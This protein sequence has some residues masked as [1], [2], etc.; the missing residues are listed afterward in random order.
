MNVEYDSRLTDIPESETVNCIIPRVARLA[1][2][3]SIALVALVSLQDKLSAVGRQAQAGR[4]TA[5]TTFGGGSLCTLS[6]TTDDVPTRCRRPALSVTKQIDPTDPDTGDL[7]TI[8]F[9]ITGLGPKPVDVVL[10]QDV[11]GSMLTEDAADG[12]TRLA[13]AQAAASTFVK[14]LTGTY[15]VAVVALSDTARLTRT[16]TPYTNTVI[17]AL[18]SLT[19]CHEWHTN[20]GG[21]IISGYQ[22]LISSDRY[23]S[24]FVKAMILLSDGSANR[25]GSVISAEQYALSQTKKARDCGILIY[26]IGFG[27]T[28]EL[29]EELLYTIAYTTGG[30]YYYSPDGSD[31]DTIYQEIALELRNLV[32]TD[33]LPPGVIL[34]CDLLPDDWICIKGSGF[35]TI[36]IPVSNSAI[37]TD[38][39]VLS[40]TTTVH[41]DP[42][43]NGPI[44]ASGSEICYDGPVITPCQAFEN[45]TTT[46][47]G[48]KV[49]GSVFEDLDRDGVLDTGEEDILSG[50]QLTASNALT[51]VT[52]ISGVY[53]FRT[54]DRPT[55]T[56]AVR[57][58]PNFIATTSEITQIPPFSGT[59]QWNFGLYTGLI[60]E[61][62]SV[63][64]NGPPLFE[65]DTL[66]YTIVVRN[67][68]TTL[69]PSVVITD[70]IP[71]FT[72]Y[73]SDSAHITPSGTVTVTGKTLTGVIDSLLPEGTVT[74]TFLVTVDIGATGQMIS[75]TAYVTST[76]QR[77]ILSQ[78]DQEGPYRVAPLPALLLDLAVSDRVIRPNTKVI[79]S[80]IV[81]NV[82]TI[83]TL[84]N[85]VVTDSHVGLISPTNFGLSPSES[86][87]LDPAE[88]TLTHNQISTAVVTSGV[89]GYSSIITGEQATITVHVIEGISLTQI[90][91]EPNPM[92]H[93]D[94]ITL[95]YSVVNQDQ[96]DSLVN[97]T[98][99]IRDSLG[100]TF[101][102]EHFFDL[103]PGIPVSLS[104]FLNVS[105]DIVITITATATDDIEQVL[106]VSDQYTLPLCPVDT[107]EQEND[108]ERPV[109]RCNEAS[110]SISVGEQPQLHDFSK[111]G[112]NG[113]DVDW[114]CFSTDD[115][116][117]PYTF[118]AHPRSSA[119]V[120]I[121]LTLFDASSDH[122]RASGSN[123][124]NPTS[125]VR[126]GV[127]F[128]SNP[129]LQPFHILDKYDYHLKVESA[130]GQS[131]CWTDY[132]LWVEEGWPVHIWLPVILRKH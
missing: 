72:S 53:V 131:G 14:A 32:I 47:G 51:S 91:T 43:Y 46:V 29:N 103:Y 129:G 49:T 2:A 84:T 9:I 102:K 68:S 98:I 60:E 17:A 105:H 1:L 126:L 78:L 99:R 71:F 69:Y 11:S 109:P 3:V 125:D 19:A 94:S 74:I 22:E 25:P 113:Q 83:A 35:T 117:T 116:E 56:V 36:T 101:D 97:G 61:K 30:E 89:K 65:E 100:R 88:T 7:V 54:S 75:N 127:L 38:P 15:R 52:D 115:T 82:S 13:V 119:G 122:P 10:L 79:Y 55:L 123:L 106:A 110:V 41:L 45:P 28:A 63:D 18:D 132:E 70:A 16:L 44:N 81:S 108:N 128:S 64:T 21:G 20:I 59:Y 34:D 12:Q 73:V 37:V 31:L 121:T 107:Y 39:F 66:A 112:E 93:G 67:I 77:R 80:Y 62:H 40:F 114:L 118:V 96:D 23:S 5:M 111:T 26:T 90:Y 124:G 86:K 85:V 8:T 48:R 57:V 4:N 87:M 95:Y 50:I 27:D 92:Y 24:T 58:P 6:A 33:V 42:K 76:A 130:D 104:S 120:A